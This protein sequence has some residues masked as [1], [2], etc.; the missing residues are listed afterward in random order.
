MSSAE[1][2]TSPPTARIVA[3]LALVAIGYLL[4][5]G[6]RT[7]AEVSGAPKGGVA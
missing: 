3:T 6:R 2:Q 5:R 4:V 1:S 7:A